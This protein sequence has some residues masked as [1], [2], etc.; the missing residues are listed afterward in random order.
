MLISF[1]HSFPTKCKLKKNGDSAK[2]FAVTMVMV[3]ESLKLNTRNL[4]WS[5]I[6][7]AISLVFVVPAFLIFGKPKFATSTVIVFNICSSARIRS[8][9]DTGVP[10]LQGC[11]I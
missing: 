4:V 9:S 5:H 10:F 2:Y 3:G 6:T 7:I 11:I 1:S 8:L